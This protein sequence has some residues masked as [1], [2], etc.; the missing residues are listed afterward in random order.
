VADQPST[1]D[2]DDDDCYYGEP[3]DKA[4]AAA[5]CA[6]WR[7]QSAQL[8]RELDQILAEQAAER[9]AGRNPAVSIE[10]PDIVAE[11]TRNDPPS[12]RKS[13]GG[14]KERGGRG[15][16]DLFSALSADDDAPGEKQEPTPPD[17]EGEKSADE[18]S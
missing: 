6:G 12:R 11:N 4:A 13:L 8:N 14:R 7:E 17:P 18:L 16:L 9:A 3:Y 1:S 10:L 15:Q 5:A 2:D